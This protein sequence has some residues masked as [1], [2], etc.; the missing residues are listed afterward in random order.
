MRG[1]QITVEQLPGILWEVNNDVDGIEE[2]HGV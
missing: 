1:G 2:C